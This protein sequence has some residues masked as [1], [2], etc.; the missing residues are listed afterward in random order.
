MKKATQQEIARKVAAESAFLAGYKPALDVRPNFRY[1]DYL[2]E[3]YPYIDEQDKYQNHLFFQTTQQKDEFLTR[4]EHLD[5]HAMNPA[6]ARELGLVLGYP[7]KSVD[8]FVWYITEETKGTQE[9][10]LEEGKIGI[11]YAGIDFASHIDLLIEEVQWLWNTYD[12]P[13]ARECISFVRVEDDLYRLEYGN[14]EQLKKIEQYLR[15]ELGLTT[16]A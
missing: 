1:F 13:F 7:Q 15:K 10:T 5:H 11:K 8:Y 2:K 16:V 9:S 6:Y 4:T 12:H 3:N 14:E